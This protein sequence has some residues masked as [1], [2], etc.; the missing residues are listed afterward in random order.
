MAAELV[1]SVVVVAA[2]TVKI[3]QVVEVLL[4]HMEQL[5]HLVH[6]VRAQ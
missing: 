4:V 2:N 6:G 1:V 5:L 3:L